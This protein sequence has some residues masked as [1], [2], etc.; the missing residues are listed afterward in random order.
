MN[1]TFGK[2][3]TINGYKFKPASV[4]TVIDHI[5]E[6]FGI[7]LETYLRDF[8]GEDSVI[9]DLDKEQADAIITYLKVN[10]FSGTLYSEE[11]II[12]TLDGCMIVYKVVS[13]IMNIK[14]A[15]LKYVAFGPTVYEDYNP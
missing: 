2:T 4:T 5:Y 1:E 6:T 3:M 12:L 9:H 14:D 15:V 13:E 10:D 7:D 11:D 8:G